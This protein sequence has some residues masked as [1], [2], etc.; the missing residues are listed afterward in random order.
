MTLKNNKRL[1]SRRLA[2]LALVILLSTFGV[3]CSTSNVGKASTTISGG[4]LGAAIAYEA[5]DGDQA[6]TAA[7]AALGTLTALGANALAETNERKAFRS[8]YETAMNQSV[9]QQYWII[10]NRQKE[11]TFASESTKETFVPVKIPEQ[12]INGEIRSERIIYVRAK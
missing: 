10:Q 7:G 4:A 9:K 1:Q 2:A 11:D 5:S 6:W 12:E 8:G 3:G